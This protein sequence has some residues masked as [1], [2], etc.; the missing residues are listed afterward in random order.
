[1]KP[2][3]AQLLYQAERDSAVVNED[4]LWLVKHG[5]TR[6]DLRRNI[7]RRPSLW[8]RFEG[9]LEKLPSCAAQEHLQKAETHA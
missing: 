2:T 1:M 7:V 3:Q 4:F 5:M 6:E 8:K 9:W